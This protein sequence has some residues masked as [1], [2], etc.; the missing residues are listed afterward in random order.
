[1]SS[2]GERKHRPADADAHRQKKKERPEDVFDA[3]FRAPA[4]Q[5]TKGQRYDHGEQHKRL[6]MAQLQHGKT[7]HALRPRAAS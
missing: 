3:I 1:M 4:A 7:A 5:K 6:E 2:T